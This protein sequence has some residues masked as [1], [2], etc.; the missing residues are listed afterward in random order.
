[1]ERKDAYHLRYAERL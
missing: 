1:M